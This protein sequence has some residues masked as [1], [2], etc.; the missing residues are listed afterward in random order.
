VY[1]WVN[2]GAFGPFP[3]MY[4]PVWYTEK[5]LSAWAEGI[6]GLAALALYAV[7][8]AQARATSSRTPVAGGIAHSARG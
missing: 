8:H 1:A 4:D 3:N 5:T 2:V 6:A 7:L